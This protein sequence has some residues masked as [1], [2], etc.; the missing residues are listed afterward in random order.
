MLRLSRLVAR[1]FLLLIVPVWLL[2]GCGSQPPPTPIPVAVEPPVVSDPQIS[3]P[4]PQEPGQEIGIAID[5]SSATGVSLTYDWRADGGEIVR[6]QNSPAITYR[7]PDEPGI[8][9]VRV[10][11]KWGDS[12]IE[13]ITTIRV[14]AP[15]VAAVDEPPP[16]PEATKE[17]STATPVPPTATRKPTNTPERPTDTPTPESTEIPPTN[18]PPPPTP[19]TAS[20]PGI[21]TI[22]VSSL[23]PNIPW[24]P[25]DPNAVPVTYYYGFDLTQSPFDNRLVRQAFA[26]AIDRQAIVNV[27]NS[28]GHKEPRPATT[29]IPASVLGREI[30]REIGLSFNPGKAR[31]LLAQ[32]GYPNGDGFPAVTLV[33]NAS[34]GHQ[35]IANAVVTMWRDNLSVY[36]KVESVDDWNTY[37]DRL[38]NN[39][40]AIYRLGWAADYVD[41]D[42]FL[43]TTFGLGDSNYGQFSNAEFSQ[44]V[45][46]AEAMSSDPQGRQALY[47]QADQILSEQE[48]AVIPVYHYFVEQ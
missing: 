28:H 30:Y 17:P 21:E 23:A 27:A 46:Q 26:L 15:E 5:V 3:A 37:L 45:E 14:E 13:K 11:V 19:T 24:L 43:N 8:Y 48:A 44:L 47:I 39:T 12:S 42:N 7:T 34:E 36:V 4:T 6:G 2:S 31:E 25:L 35:A 20:L 29:F 33:F 18:T 9:N 22:P 1:L 40:P 16:A 32:A 38:A 41:P 10:A